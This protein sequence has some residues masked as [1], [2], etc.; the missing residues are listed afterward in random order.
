MHIIASIILSAFFLNTPDDK[1]SLKVKPSSE[2]VLDMEMNKIAEEAASLKGAKLEYK[3]D[4]NNLQSIKVTFES[5]ILFDFGK[6]ILNNAAKEALTKIAEIII[7]NPSIG[8]AISGHSDNIGSLEAN[9]QIS[10][11]R[12]KGVAD[13]LLS[14]NVPPS[15]LKEIVG[16]NFSEP[17]ADNST[18]IGR[19]ANRHAAVSINLPLI[20][21]DSTIVKGSN[22][23]AKHLPPSLQ[24]LLQTIINKPKNTNVNEVEIDGLLVDDTKTKAGKDFYDLFYSKWEAPENAKDYTITISEKPFRLTSTIITVSINDNYVYQ[25]FLQPRLDIIE[26]TTEDAILYTQSYL[27]SYAEIMKQLNGEDMSGS[28]IF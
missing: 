14:K 7:K 28:G 18:E 16:K 25:S 17:I 1:D 9:Q 26:A 8:I 22:S 12:A 24:K 10:E 13:F 20:R 6:R 3:T 2:V 15:Q 5:T 23:K 4:I 19:S 11:E 27:S 21:N